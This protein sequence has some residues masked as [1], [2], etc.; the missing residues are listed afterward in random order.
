MADTAGERRPPTV[1]LRWPA[2]V[3]IVSTQ[4]PPVGLFE[5]VADPRDLE[6][7]VAVAALTDPHARDAAGELSLVPLEERVSG[8]GSSDAMTPFTHPPPDGGRFNDPG[9]GAWY[10]AR[11]RETAVAETAFHRARVLR[12]SG[13]PTGEVSVRVLVAR[14]A[15]TVHDVRGK[16]EDFPGIDEPGTADYAAARALARTLRSEDSH[17]IAYDSVR[18]PG[19]ECVVLFSPRHVGLPVVEE[20]ILRYA[21]NARTQRIESVHEVGSTGPDLPPDSV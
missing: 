14:V 17:G 13:S 12:A 18:R 19:G 16:A 15:T 4:F 5:S 20:A 3:R 10:A 1:A 11:D 9:V 7:V 2:A 8:P 6:E 21:W